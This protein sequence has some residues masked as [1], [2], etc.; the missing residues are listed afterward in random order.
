MKGAISEEGVLKKLLEHMNCQIPSKRIRLSELLV[1]SEPH[2]FGR[3]GVE[4]VISREELRMMKDSIDIIGVSDI[5]LPIVIMADSSHEQ[6][7]WKVEG[8]AECAL[9]LHL[10]AKDN[11][12]R[13][14]R[15]FLYAPH[16]AILRRKLP[17]A[18]VCMLVP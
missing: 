9:V 6:S 11:S 4:Y 8:E 18:T 2:Y 17:T 16:M 3:D 12:D 10:L 13:K 1:M 14:E 5:K 7:A 15:V